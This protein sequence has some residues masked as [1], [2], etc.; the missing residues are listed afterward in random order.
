M[1][2]KFLLFI[3]MI[4]GTFA[5]AQ[6]PSFGVRA[7]LTSSGMRGDAITSLNSLLDYTDGYITTGNRTGFFAGGFANIPLG[8]VFSI[9][10]ALYYSQKGYELRGSLNVKGAEFLGVNAKAGLN[11]QYID[12][13]V[14]AKANF[15]G[16]EVFA[17]PQ[18]SYLSSATLKTSAGLLGFDLLKTSTDATPVFNKWDAAITAGIGYNFSNG[19]NIRAAY[20]Y[21]LMKTD[22]AHLLNAYNRSI[23]LGI[24]FNF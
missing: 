8:E 15:N 24:G 6:E 3:S 9:E 20:D 19:L 4:I 17:G 2:R 21:G 22:A 10:P 12:L 7:G 1:K 11:M 5:I 14:V 16:F 13:P 23:K 18:I